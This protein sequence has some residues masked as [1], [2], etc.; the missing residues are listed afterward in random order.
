MIGITQAQLMGWLAEWFWPFV[1]I[2]A[3]FAVAPLFSSRQLPTRV[4]IGLAGFVSYLIGPLLPALPQVA[5]LSLEGLQII[6]Q[7]ILIGIGIGF[8]LQ[9][10][11]DAVG[12]AGQLIANSMGLSFAFNVDPLRGVSTT[13]VGQF[14]VLL[15]TLT[16]LTLDGH[17]AVIQ[18][19]VDGFRTLPIGMDGIGR[20]GVWALALSGGLLF[21]G[22]LQ[23]AL[24]GITALVVSNLAFGLIS[25]SAPTLNIFSVGFPISL[26]FGLLVLQFGLPGVQQ[27][28]LELLRQAFADALALQQT[29]RP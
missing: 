6:V 10:A 14:Y 28:F 15:A 17:L 29:P 13:A 4:K 19:L 12:I 1:R 20:E 27:G 23:I 26:V 21:S 3:C 22:A 18:L 16:F 5:L 7:Q 11:F 8:I 25:R 9:L 2:A 24:P